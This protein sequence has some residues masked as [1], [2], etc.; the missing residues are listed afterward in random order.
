M[1]PCIA[2]ALNKQIVVELDAAYLYM[3]MADWLEKNDLSGFGSWMRKQAHEEVG[4]AMI[5]FNFLKDRN[6]AV[7]LGNVRQQKYFFAS[8]KDVMDKLLAQGKCIAGNISK[9]LGLA[10]MSEDK[11][12]AVLLAWFAAVQLEEE[13]LVTNV[14]LRVNNSYRDAVGDLQEIDA[15]LAQRQGTIPALLKSQRKHGVA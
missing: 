10:Q 8:V 14:L 3:Q 5:I 6:A 7:A 9:I 12:A 4:H 2:N 13:E 15:E 11:E 1:D